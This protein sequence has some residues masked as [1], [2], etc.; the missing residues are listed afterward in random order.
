MDL[1][2][3][4]VGVSQIEYDVHINEV[5]KVGC[6]ASEETGKIRCLCFIQSPI[7]TWGFY[8]FFNWL[9]ISKSGSKKKITYIC[10]NIYV[11][12]YFPPPHLLNLHLMPNADGW[13]PINHISSALSEPAF[14]L[15]GSCTHAPAQGRVTGFT[16]FAVHALHLHPSLC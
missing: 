13:N 1:F 4:T 3:G 6:D 8:F 7:E 16:S 9:E 12:I 15:Q 14:G 11:Y 2:K 10:T 5:P